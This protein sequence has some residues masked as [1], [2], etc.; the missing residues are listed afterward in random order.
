MK[1]LKI[2]SIPPAHGDRALMR[3]VFVNLLSNATKY[4]RLKEQSVTV[5][6]G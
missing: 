2:E 6:Q 3:Q 5:E 4:S 1:K